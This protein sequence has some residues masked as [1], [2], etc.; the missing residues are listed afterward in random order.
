MRMLNFYLING[1]IIS[2]SLGCMY[3]IAPNSGAV[4]FRPPT[5]INKFA[6]LLKGEHSQH[7]LIVL[8]LTS[9]RRHA[10]QMNS[11]LLSTLIPTSLMLNSK[12]KF[13]YK[14]IH[15]FMKYQSY[16]K[17][18]DLKLCLNAECNDCEN[19]HNKKTIKAKTDNLK[20]HIHKIKQLQFQS[21]LVHFNESQI[22]VDCAVLIM[23]LQNSCAQI[24]VICVSMEL[25]NLLLSYFPDLDIVIKDFI[26]NILTDESNNIRSS[27]EVFDAIGELLES[28]SISNQCNVGEICDRISKLR[29]KEE[30]GFKEQKEKLLLDDPIHIASSSPT[31][32]N[33]ELTF[34]NCIDLRK[35]KV[36]AKK[37]EKVERRL[38]QK[39]EKRLLEQSI[40]QNK[41]ND[42][43][44]T[45]SHRSNRREDQC[46]SRGKN[47]SRDVNIESLDI[48]FGSKKLLTEAKLH[49]TPGKRYG[50][51][52]RNGV[53]K[54]TLL[55]M[56]SGGQIR[57]PSHISILHVEQEVTGDDTLV[58]D[59]VLASDSK[60]QK[61]LEEEEEIR[62]QLANRD[63]GNVSN[64]RLGEIYDELEA[65]EADKAP[66]RASSILYGLGFD[67]EDQKRPTREFSG[68]WR[69][70]IALAQALFLKPDLLLL[71]EPTNMLDMKTVIWLENYLL[72][73]P[74][75]LVVV[76]HDRVFLNSISN[77]IIYMHSHQLNY[78]AGNYDQFEKTKNE[79]MINQRREYEAQKQF[80]EHVQEFIDRFR[81][82]AKRASLV[83]SK[84]K[85]LEK[86]PELK[87]LELD[88]PVVLRFP[89][90]EKLNPPILKLDN[91]SFR[92]NDERVIFDNVTFT[93]DMESRICLVGD[94]GSGKT[95]FLKLLTGMLDP[96]KGERHAHRLLK[97]GYFTQHH[98]DQLIMDINPVQLME[99]KYPGKKYEEYRSSLGRFGITGDLA[100]QTIRLLSGGQKS[101]LAFAMLCLMNPNFLI[102][103]EPTNHLD[104]ETVDALGEAINQFNGGVIIVTHEE[105]LISMVCKELVIVSDGKVTQ[106]DGGLRE[107]KAIVDKEVLDV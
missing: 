32:F 68:G 40:T 18:C 54:T 38:Q 23:L 16:A 80:K 44:A 10:S 78:F 27:S 49:L 84:I 34:A 96:V 7:A 91:V 100:L 82:N 85:M 101:R 93:A 12:Q 97:I 46:E 102:L 26:L 87:P 74:S 65:I 88:A 45:V 3:H 57:I 1:T 6:L 52:G 98:V 25:E 64:R 105:R 66:A 51:V 47:M 71:D 81:Y 2:P 79:M 69:M 95:T 28:C 31:S 33:D 39:Q 17:I 43:T 107:Y 103:D 77:E 86:L 62:S 73:W 19:F 58:I 14:L 106:L 104:I 53:G 42:I 56:I 60:R 63:E 35:S 13:A 67:D 4:G 70:R 11:S 59:C 83:Q 99:L 30:P 61:L 41:S 21:C 24:S 89:D 72:T 29:R 5:P 90:T 15:I 76:S 75:I 20:V 50:L 55:K 92:Y 9:K 48:S 94:N 36:D 8:K 22:F 37:L